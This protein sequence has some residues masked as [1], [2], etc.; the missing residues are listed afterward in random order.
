MNP[1][2]E[3]D[4]RALHDL[5]APTARH[6]PARGNAPGEVVPI[7]RTHFRPIYVMVRG[8]EIS[9]NV[10]VIVAVPTLL[11]RMRPFGLALSAPSVVFN[12]QH[13]PREGASSCLL[14]SG[15]LGP[16]FLVRCDPPARSA[17]RTLANP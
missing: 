11:R 5:G 17:L 6:T 1:T 3:P 16:G 8:L 15:P 9:A 12:L 13:A 7:H 10:L 14:S 4:M 2:V